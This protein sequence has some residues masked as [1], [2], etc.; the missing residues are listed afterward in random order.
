MQAPRRG[1]ANWRS[2]LPILAVD[3]ISAGPRHLK[4]DQVQN[5]QKHQP[6]MGSTQSQGTESW[7]V[8]P[9]AWQHRGLV[10]FSDFQ[11]LPLLVRPNVRD[12]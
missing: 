6:G 7:R 9:N 12:L 8:G 10:K 2:R 1:S 4:T 3:Q 5:H 11:S